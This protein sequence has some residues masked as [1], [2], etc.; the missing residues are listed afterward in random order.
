MKKIIKVLCC[1]LSAV[2]LLSLCG[3]QDNP[4]KTIVQNKNV[5]IYGSQQETAPKETSVS[6]EAYYKHEDAFNST[7]NTVAFQVKIDTNIS[8]TPMPVVEV[9]PHYLSEQDARHIADVLFDNA[10]Y[11]DS[12]PTLSRIYS[13]SEILEKINRWS[14]YTNLDAVQEL[15]G[16]SM[17][18][19]VKIVQKF[20][21][22]YT[23]LC[24]TAPEENPHHLS[25]W[26][27]KKSLQYVYTEEYLKKEK[28]DLSDDHE[29]ISVSVCKD[30]VEYQYCVATRNM[31][32]FKLN[33]ICA[34]PYSGLSPY[35]IDERI[36]RAQLC[37]TEKPS[38]TQL[39][40]VNQIV[41]DFLE[42]MNLGSWEVDQTK[43]QISYFGD[44]T[45]YVICVDAVPVLNGVAATRH[46]QLE[47][48]KS[49]NEYA[50]NYLLT[51]V[52]FEF[53]ANGDLLLF[54]LDS[55]IKVKAVLT[56]NARTLEINELMDRAKEC[57]QLSDYYAYGFGSAIDES[58]EEIGCHVLICD[59]EYGLT[60]VKVPNSDES[61]YY[62]P[63]ITLRGNI[64]YF[65]KESGNVC[66][67]NE[68]AELLVLNAVDGSII[69]TRNE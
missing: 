37:R 26:K 44:A 12:E 66:F 20:I 23:I 49:T 4:N 58:N 50:S 10:I 57:F 1:A 28:I 16:S 51:D 62:V 9:I 38:D 55:P 56:E 53:S 42:K 5:E 69:H 6:N 45:E 67:E 18:N 29:K 64:E 65:I 27:Y 31:S 8:Q 46:T 25:D 34:Y 68:N 48:L 61:Y 2:M 30:S 3:C 63:S 19:V 43:V 60:R 17:D 52:H 47:N 32:D 33:Y 36:I 24:E 22:D 7:D 41:M 59:L 15:Y 39:E 35:D 14:K 21:S 54:Q 13:K 40:N 11:Y